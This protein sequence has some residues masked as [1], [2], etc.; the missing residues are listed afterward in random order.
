MSEE[1]PA[2]SELIALP[3]SVFHVGTVLSFALHD[4]AGRLLLPKGGRIQNKDMLEA[5]QVRGAVYVDEDES[6]ETIKAFMASFNEASRRD[7]PL[8]DID[9]FAARKSEAVPDSKPQ[10]TPQAWSEIESRLSVILGNLAIRG[11]AGRDA[12]KRLDAVI[13]KI[14]QLLERDREASIFLLVHRA[15]SGFTGYST[16]HSLICG[17]VVH[18]MNNVLKLSPEEGS[19]LV[20]AALTMNVS[21]KGLQDVMASQ[22]E[23]ASQVQLNQIDAH[24]RESVRMLRD[25]G[26][27]NELWLETIA[28]HHEALNSEIPL[29]QRPPAE[30]TAK[31]LQVV[32][33][34]TAAMSPRRSRSGRESKDAVRSA[35]VVA[36]GR[37]QHD[38]VGLV[39]MQVLGLYPA[40]TYVKIASGE[41]AL[42]LRQ[43]LKPTE[44]HMASV[45][46]K[47][48]EHISEPRLLHAA[49]AEH[50]VLQG[51][52]A[53]L[54]RV[55]INEDVMLRQ[56]ASSRG[57]ATDRVL[58]G[59]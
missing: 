24:P 34:Y 44:P 19:S 37:G 38:E 57:A 27:T 42:V 49:R 54:I 53:S 31:I 36:G 14:M 25:A 45:L 1:L 51:I 4:E 21:I 40:G 55:R 18:M 46:N 33:R 35:I 8:K 52:S 26:V 43:G 15:V 29:A 6:R 32:D 12:L 2:R 59:R 22:K 9:K 58:Y 47:R 30:R 56:L 50:A 39:L 48:S 20:R 10:S 3:T 5:L 13:E 11:D 7:A 16:L 17:A 28:M 41:T 23:S